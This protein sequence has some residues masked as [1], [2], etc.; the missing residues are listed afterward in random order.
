MIEQNGPWQIA[1]SVLMADFM[2]LRK[3]NIKSGG[4]GVKELIKKKNICSIV[5]I[6]FNYLDHYNN[7]YP[8]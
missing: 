8:I 5:I 1:K 2:G 7:Q 4:P 6:L 3:N